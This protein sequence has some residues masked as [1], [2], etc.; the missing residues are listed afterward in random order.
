[1]FPMARSFAAGS[2]AL[3]ALLTSTATTTTATTTKTTTATTATTATT[4]TATTKTATTKTAST[5]TAAT[6]TT[7]ATPTPTAHFT[8][9]LRGSYAAA[10]AVGFNVFDVSGSTSNPAGVKTKLNALPAG[11]KAMIWVG[12]LGKKAGVQGFTRAQFQAQVNALATDPRVFGYFIAD[13]PHPILFPTVVAEIR[14][15][16]DYLRAKAP[17]QKSFIVVLDGSKYC[18][19]TLGCEYAALAPSKS[20]VDV[21]G[22]DSYPCHLGAP[23][24]FTKIPQRVNAAI[25]A[26]IPRGQ[27]APVYQSFGQEGATNPYYRTP[28]AA[29][30]QKMLDTWKANL[31]APVMDYA[32]SW[33]TQTSSPQAL[34][35]HPELQRV[36]RTHNA[37]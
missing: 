8:V 4:K 1:M 24:D 22:V 21:V 34:I 32:Y 25:K 6:A 37:G 14:A 17:A 3:T 18:N 10:R 28:T 15:R 27:I 16:A 11:S 7:A 5:N 23:C 12:N 35:N 13:E 9:N 29:E 20:H 36:A 31:P 33:G 30:L 19:G 2:F 26:G